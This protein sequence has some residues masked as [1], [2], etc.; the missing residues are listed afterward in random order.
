MLG[1]VKLIKINWGY[2]YF[3][4]GKG[5]QINIKKIIMRGIHIYCKCQI[6]K[7]K[8]NTCV[9]TKLKRICGL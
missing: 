3:I 1:H 9:V 8:D 2:Y 6:G 7:D 4:A 5:S